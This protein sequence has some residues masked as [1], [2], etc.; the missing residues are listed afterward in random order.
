MIFTSVNP[1]D[2]YYVYAYLR[3]SDNSPYYIGKG[4]DT[5]AWKKARGEIGKP[6]NDTYIVILEQNLTEIGALAIERRMIAWYGRIDLGTG[7]LRNKTDG[8]DGGNGIKLTI[9]Q[10]SKI[11]QKKKGKKMKPRSPEH[12]ARL[13]ASKSGKNN[14]NYGKIYLPEERLK[15]SLAHKGK[16]QTKSGLTRTGLKRGP[17]KKRSILISTENAP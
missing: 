12:C 2:G 4:K 10:R 15:L 9:E 1:P 11:S 6:K 17:Y 5:R 8:G 13:S 3:A 7:I 14:P 16:P